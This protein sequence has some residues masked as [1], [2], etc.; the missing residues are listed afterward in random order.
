MCESVG[1]EIKILLQKFMICFV[2]IDT[3]CYCYV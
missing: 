2:K 1:E 3:K